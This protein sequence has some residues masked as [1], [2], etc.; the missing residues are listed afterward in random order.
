MPAGVIEVIPKA[1]GQTNR[2]GSS[3]VPHSPSVRF[4]IVPMGKRRAPVV[5]ASAFAT[6]QRCSENGG[7]CY[8]E[9]G[10]AWHECYRCGFYPE[11]GVASTPGRLCAPCMHE[12]VQ[13][14][15]KCKTSL[16]WWDH[17]WENR[18][19]F[20]TFKGGDFLEG[21][22]PRPAARAILVHLRIGMAQ[23]PHLQTG[24]LNRLRQTG[25]MGNT[26]CGWAPQRCM[27]Q[28]AH[29]RISSPQV[30][31]G[32]VRGSRILTLPGG[33]RSRHAPRVS[34]PTISSQVSGKGWAPLVPHPA[35]HHKGLRWP[36]PDLPVSGWT[37]ADGT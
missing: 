18:K 2:P 12:S 9:C 37:R 8:G 20:L 6:G 5:D 3:S 1:V 26:F 21:V 31:L 7:T 24:H 22:L 27:A 29:V 4:D 35:S 17:Q 30:H 25:V 28:A 11:E 10:L 33:C 32:T 34:A 19:Q 15:C 13:D 36:R 14:C 16:Y 23:T